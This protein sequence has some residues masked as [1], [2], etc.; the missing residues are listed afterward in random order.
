MNK[1]E[2]ETPAKNLHITYSQSCLR[3]FIQQVLNQGNLRTQAVEQLFAQGC[4]LK[5]QL[6]IH[7]IVYYSIYLKSFK[8]VIHLLDEIDLIKTDIF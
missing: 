5:G 4:L 2:S 8:A 6:Y 1:C 3:G 7:T